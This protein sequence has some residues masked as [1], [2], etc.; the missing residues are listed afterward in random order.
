MS[1][2]EIRTSGS[3]SAEAH[4]GARQPRCRFCSSALSTTFVNL[5]MSPLCQTHIS[6]EQLNSMEPFYPLHA[7]VCDQ[8]FLVQLEQFVAPDE[9]FTDYAYLS[10]Y[11][12]SWVEHARRYAIAMQRRFGLTPKTLDRY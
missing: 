5:G 4:V 12:D 9:I 7:Y 3:S 6:T 11:S 2:N 8:C 10:S 1:S